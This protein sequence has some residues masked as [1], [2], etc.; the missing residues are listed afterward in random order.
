MADATEFLGVPDL[1]DATFMDFVMSSVLKDKTAKGPAK[2]RFR[3]FL[4]LRTS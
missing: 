2:K 4:A 1:C 3:L